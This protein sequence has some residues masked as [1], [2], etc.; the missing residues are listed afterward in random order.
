LSY[1][2]V[3]SLAGTFLVFN[4]IGIGT[5]IYYSQQDQDYKK[6][7][8]RI[9]TFP[10]LIAFIVAFSIN[11]TNVVI[12]PFVNE[13]LGKLSAPFSVLALLAIGM[14]LDLRI[15]RSFLKNIFILQINPCTIDCICFIMAHLRNGRRCGKSLQ[16]LF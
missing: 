3:L 11:M 15:E 16:E 8:K 9:L 1:G 12:P 10:P 2:I 6:L 13:L 4:T 14:Q 7:I 5:V